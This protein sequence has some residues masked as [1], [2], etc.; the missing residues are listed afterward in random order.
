MRARI[1]LTLH[2]LSLRLARRIL[3]P[4]YEFMSAT[5]EG[6]AYGSTVEESELIAEDGDGD[7]YVAT[8]DR[9]GFYEPFKAWRLR[10]L[11]A[12][13][14]SRRHLSVLFVDLDRS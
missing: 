2:V 13:F 14:A 4:W 3:L 7:L 5:G 10:H 1:W 8:W 6:Y 11:R 9:D 12:A